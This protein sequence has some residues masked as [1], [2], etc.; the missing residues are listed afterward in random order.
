MSSFSISAIA[1]ATM[2]NLADCRLMLTRA[3]ELL[4]A[5]P[6]AE[7]S[8]DDSR[9]SDASSGY[10]STVVAPNTDPDEAIL[11]MKEISNYL[12]AKSLFDCRE[13]DRC[14]AVFLPESTLTGIVSPKE[15]SSTPKG[16]GKGKAA[17]GSVKPSSGQ[18]IPNISQRS[19]SSP[20]TPSSCLARS[21]RMKTPRW[22]WVLRILA[23][24]R[25]NN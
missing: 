8:L 6:E 10:A 21:G 17:V 3:A 16:K 9:V 22:S 2:G 14:A 12:L 20:Y 1:I 24:V 15:T 19:Y 23:L 11:E 7:I 5:I 13:Y 18:A 4:T 25:T